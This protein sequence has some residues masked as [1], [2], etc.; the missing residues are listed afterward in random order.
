MR[1]DDFKRLGVVSFVPQGAVLLDVRSDRLI[2]L[3]GW[4]REGQV[5]VPLQAKWWLVPTSLPVKNVE[6]TA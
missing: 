5:K 1:E 2:C 6:V 4:S 3:S